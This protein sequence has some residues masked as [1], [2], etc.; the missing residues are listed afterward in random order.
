MTIC[1]KLLVASE[2]NE[3]VLSTSGDC[4]ALSERLAV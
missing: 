4:D 2:Y 3:I 1:D